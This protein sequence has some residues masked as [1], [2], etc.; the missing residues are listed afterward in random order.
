[1]MVLIS[2]TPRDAI[3]FR[4]HSRFCAIVPAG[5]ARVI[6]PISLPGLFIVLVPAAMGLIFAGIIKEA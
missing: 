4:F 2:G 6:S 3:V 5:P 1:M